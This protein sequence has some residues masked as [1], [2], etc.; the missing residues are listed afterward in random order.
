MSMTSP[1]QQDMN[2][3]YIEWLQNENSMLR[4]KLADYGEIST[5]SDKS[6]N[7]IENILRFVCFRVQEPSFGTF[8]RSQSQLQILSLDSPGL[9]ARSSSLSPDTSGLYPNVATKSPTA[10]YGKFSTID[11]LNRSGSSGN[12]LAQKMA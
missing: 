6:F 1:H 4:A 12:N 11:T 2:P 3:R 5:F 9:R 10:N 8:S 7:Y